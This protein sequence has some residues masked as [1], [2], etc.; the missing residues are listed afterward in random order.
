[1]RLKT[2]PTCQTLAKALAR[3]SDT[4]RLLLGKLKKLGKSIKCISKHFCSWMRRPETKIEIR[5]K[6]WAYQFFLLTI[7]RRLTRLNFEP[8]A[9]LRLSNNLVNKIHI[10]QDYYWKDQEI[11]IKDQAQGSSEP[12]LEHHQDQISWRN[13]EQVWPS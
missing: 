9:H 3:S 5:K 13:Q 10:L 6:T 4:A 2:W 8:A 12:P 7:E 1:M 11:F